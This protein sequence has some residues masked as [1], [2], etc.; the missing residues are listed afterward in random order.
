MLY[1]QNERIKMKI[2]IITVTY[3]SANTLKETLE[4]VKNQT[5]K[6]IEHII[7]DGNS[8]DNTLKIIAQFSN[9]SQVISE[10]DKGIY[11]AMRKG[12]ALATGTVIGILN[13]DDLFENDNTIQEI[14]DTF[15]R[16]KSIDAVYGNL[17]YFKT[18]SPNKII[19]FWKSNTYYSTFFED[20]FVMPHPTLFL[21][22][23]VYDKIGSYYPEFKIS[24][25][26]EL[27]LRA[28]KIN[29]FKPF[30]LDQTIVKMRMGGDS[31]RNIW[32]NVIG[33]KEIYQ[34][35]KMNGLKMPLLFYPKRILYK[36]KQ[37]INV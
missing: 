30:Y 9:I 10:P 32:S 5:Y 23:L 37:I 35:W 12:V 2:T 14:V 19:R 28:F 26:Y 33:N 25:D 21:K 24:S 36:L 15:Q 29:N 27:M 20:G 17:S 6:N 4:S 7:I 11:D 22:K 16:E 1:D 8:S 18:E 34:A 31:T 13:S 3:N